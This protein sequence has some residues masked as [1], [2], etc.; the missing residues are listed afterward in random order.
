MRFD[1]FLMFDSG[2]TPMLEWPTT[3]DKAAHQVYFRPARLIWEP[4]RIQPRGSRE[5]ARPLW[6]AEDQRF[7]RQLEAC[8]SRGLRGARLADDLSLGLDTLHAPLISPGLS[9]AGRPCRPWGM[10]I[11][12]YWVGDVGVGGVSRR[13]VL[14]LCLPVWFVAWDLALV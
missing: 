1:A 2:G 3:L 7:G 6:Q 11:G 10:S 9:H 5:R 4:P 14:L 13:V 8:K 12:F